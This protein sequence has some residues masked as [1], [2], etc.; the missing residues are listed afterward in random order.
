MKEEALS[1]LARFMDDVPAA[2]LLVNPDGVIERAGVRAEVVFGY[3]RG[4]LDGLHIRELVSKQSQPALD[5]P[6]ASLGKDPR[7]SSSE[8][9]PALTG[10]RKNGSEFP[11]RL[12]LNPSCVAGARWA[13]VTVADAKDG[14]RREEEPDAR[15]LHLEQLVKDREA[16]LAE[17]TGE[18]E[19][20][21]RKAEGFN[22]KL[23]T[24]ADTF[25]LVLDALV[26]GVA[27][28]NE[29]GDF[30]FFNPAG[31][32]ILGVG[33]VE[34]P[35]EKWPEAYGVFEPDG[36]TRMPYEELPLVKAMRGGSDDGREMVI[37]NQNNSEGVLLTVT[38]RPVRNERGELVG[39]VAVFRD[40]TIERRAQTAI[41]E[42]NALLE[43]RVRQR[44]DALEAAVNELKGVVEEHARAEKALIESKERL[45]I[46]TDSI[47]ALVAFIKRDLTFEFVNRAYSDWLGIDRGQILGHS[48]ET[49]L[50]ESFADTLPAVKEALAGKPV[51]FESQIRHSTLGPRVVEWN[52]V[53]HEQGGAIGFYALANDVTDR[54]LAKQRMLDQ[55]EEIGHVTR[56]STLGEFAAGIAHEI[57]Q[58]L[59]SV[60]SNAQAGLRF[61][62]GE[63]VDLDEIREIL[64]EIVNESWRAAQIIRQLRALLEKGK[65]DLSKLDV[66][67]V[68]K[69]MPPLLKGKLAESRVRLE[70]EL[71]PNPGLIL[72]DKIQLQQV[73][74]NLI[75]NGIEAIQDAAT[76]QRRITVRTSRVDGLVQVSVTDSGPGISEIDTE[77][78]F[79]RF[80]TTK[81]KGLGM[82]LA[83]SRSI[84]SA[85]GG[86]IWAESSAND[87][88]TFAFSLSVAE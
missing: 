60:Q 81:S 88:A 64:E 25:K 41:M 26:E 28:A 38:S 43:E 11:L 7:S 37:R 48:I 47:P 35:P 12:G 6:L 71:E 40:I 10:L 23:E 67:A 27:V 84:I 15:L 76:R 29:T 82:G 52:Y 18:L 70:L 63:S 22:K 80:Y 50:G 5:E 66:N 73:I 58:P 4:A 85:F 9:P 39:G 54:L 74:F 56:I 62:D 69:E 42:A 49:V 59:T 45:S 30:I 3:D 1:R 14:G 21:R 83:I 61:L 78:L 19:R 34:A 53:P 33:A 87:G 75:L 8:E 51:K 20:A 32:R 46:V 65:P 17:R 13:W 44:T 16:E 68:I 55:L 86:R 36:R 77:R 24:Q 72:A 2:L 31:E 57:G 79:G